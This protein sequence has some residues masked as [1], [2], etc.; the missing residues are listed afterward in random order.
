MS[1]LHGERREGNHTDIHA[2]VTSGNAT[3]ATAEQAVADKNSSRA[4]ADPAKPDAC[5][6]DGA[7]D[8][9][10]RSGLIARGA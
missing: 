4:G 2:K 3:S 9:P 5:A 1:K 7:R 8:V 6:Y 10:A